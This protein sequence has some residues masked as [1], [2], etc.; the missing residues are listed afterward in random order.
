MAKAEAEYNH[1]PKSPNTYHTG[2]DIGVSEGAIVRAAASGRIVKIQENDV[3]C[4]PD[5]RG[6]CEDHGY[7]NTVIIEQNLGTSIV[8]SQYSHLASIEEG[9]KLACGPI[10]VGRRKR[11]TCA[12]P[13]SI[14]ARVILGR[15][16]GSCYG[17]P[18]CTSLHLHFEIK[19][20]STLGTDGDD[21][22]EFGYTV[23]HPDL[24]SY[25]NPIL[26]LHSVIT[27][28][29][30]R[31]QVIQNGTN[32]RVGPGGS[33]AT[34]YRVIGQV[35]QGEE[36]DAIDNSP[37]TTTPNCPR[38]WY[39][40]RRIDGS[41]FPDTLG[42]EIPDAWVCGDFIING[43]PCHTITSSSPIPT[44]FGS[45]YDVVSSPSTNLIQTTCDVSSVRVDL[46]KGDPLQ[47]IYNTGYL[48]KPGS[49]NWMPISYT[50]TE[51]LISGAWYPKS[52]NATIPMS[53][54]ELQNQSYI[55]GYLCTWIPPAS[56]QAGM[57]KCGCRDATCTQSYWQLQGIQLMTGTHAVNM[58]QGIAADLPL[59]AADLPPPSPPPPPLSR[60]IT[61]SLNQTAFR[62]GDAL[63]VGLRAR[64]PDPA[65]IADFYFGVLLPDGVTVLFVTSLSPLDGVVTRLDADARTFRPLLAN[66]QIPQGLDTALPDFFAYTFGGGEQ[67]GT[68]T[69]LA[70]LIPSGA[71]NDGRVDVGDLLVIDAR[72]FSFS[73]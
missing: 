38:G 13:V 16:G 30:L 9:F 24:E 35:N 28:S 54:A 47:Y 4:N 68:Y 33:G 5:I 56:G 40:I 65:F 26:N 73:P 2:L 10:D 8:Y 19:D 23:N 62:T 17:Q 55:L 43:S 69:F 6:A 41:R 59:I 61:L 67:I 27:L 71:F 53:A 57:W 3:G 60:D 42:G 15:V 37:T 49:T 31:T 72:P 70:V 44:G 39:Q 36:Y 7:G 29:P 66:V 18:D 64:N 46:G 32:L 34:A 50:S 1:N 52:A 58:S 45:P 22:G 63:C 14:D 11:R 21:L 48:N 12:I 25:H 51:A 20:F